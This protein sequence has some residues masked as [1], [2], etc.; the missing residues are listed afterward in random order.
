MARTGQHLDRDIDV[1][2]ALA[3]IGGRIGKV[4]RHPRHGVGIGGGVVS[5]PAIKLVSRAATDQD[6]IAIA[7]GQDIRC[8]VTDQ[9]IGGAAASLR[10]R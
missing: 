3:R 10:L 9:D 5:C 6:I 7:P 4:C 8:A 1:T 2:L